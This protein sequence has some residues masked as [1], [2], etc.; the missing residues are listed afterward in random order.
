MLKFFGINENPFSVSPSPRFFFLSA[1]HQAIMAKVDYVLDYRQGMTVIYGDVGTGKTSLA[2][3]LIDR[4]SDNY[5]V[6]FLTNP[7]FNS[8]MHMV[9]T[10]CAEFGIEPKRS[11]YAQTEALQSYLLDAFAENRFP[12]LILDEA[13]LLKKRTLEMLRQFSN[14][15]T[16][17]QKLIQVILV[18][19]SELKNKLKKH[20]ALMSRIIMA[21]TLDSLSLEDMIEMI[22][23][24]LVD[25]AKGSMEMFEPDAID[26]IYFYS[27]GIPRA[28]IKLCSA[29]MKI[30]FIN[31]Q[32]TINSVIVDMAEQ[33]K[34]G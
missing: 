16:N 19:Q 24:R 11:L 32:K 23:F 29:A 34:E 28:T 18:G 26:K 14:F 21:S 12:V 7:N 9:K 10:V 6:V 8:E 30:A 15:E 4:L 5:E 1:H 2:R 31:Q 27:K 13:Q 17:E 22:H 20:R 33:T 3:T 25:V